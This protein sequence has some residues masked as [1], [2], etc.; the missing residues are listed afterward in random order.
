M[1]YR[2]VFLKAS[3]RG[4]LLLFLCSLYQCSSQFPDFCI[5]AKCFPYPSIRGGVSRVVVSHLFLL[6][7]FQGHLGVIQAALIFKK[8][9]YRC[10]AHCSYQK[11][12][13]R[14]FPGS[15]S[16]KLNSKILSEFVLLLMCQHSQHSPFQSHLSYQANA[17]A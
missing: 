10:T 9:I 15:L 7:P 11:S 16:A 8:N 3:Q 4:V 17:A 14:L 2:S 13:Q 6:I 12:S 1:L 5:G